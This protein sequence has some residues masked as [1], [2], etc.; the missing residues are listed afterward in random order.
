M[1]AHPDE[2]GSDL[3]IFPEAG[4]RFITLEECQ[5]LYL[6]ISTVFKLRAAVIY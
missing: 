3:R 2:V 1:S 5:V 4:W 6:C